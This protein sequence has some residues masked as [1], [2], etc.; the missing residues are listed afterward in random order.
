MQQIKQ[1]KWSCQGVNNQKGIN[2]LGI[3]LKNEV[4]KICEKPLIL[5]FGVIQDDY[6]LKTNTF[7]IPIPISDYSICR[8]VSWNPSKPMTMTWWAD[9]APYVEGW[10]DEDWSDKG[11]HGV[12]EDLHNPPKEAVPHGHGSKGES[13]IECGKHYHDVYLPDKMRWIKPND[14]VLVAWVGVDAVVIDIILNAE[15]V[16]QSE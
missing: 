3:V 7:P 11:W 15:E 6:S 4:N 13:E 9:E 5:D 16:L 14:R 10:E 12:P 8:G 2:N 1:W